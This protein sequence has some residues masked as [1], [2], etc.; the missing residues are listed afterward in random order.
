MRVYMITPTGRIGFLA[1]VVYASIQFFQTRLT[2]TECI[3]LSLLGVV[4]AQMM[5]VVVGIL[6]I[7]MSELIFWQINSLNMGNV[8]I[9]W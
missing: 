5:E 4:T 7:A 8:S 6:T 3:L 2:K 9:K 1:L